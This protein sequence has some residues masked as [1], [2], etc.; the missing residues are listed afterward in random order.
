MTASDIF[1]RLAGISWEQNETGDW[2]AIKDDR[3]QAVVGLND[4][5]LMAAT[6][7]DPKFKDFETSGPI[8]EA[9]DRV[10]KILT[11]MF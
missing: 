11:G 5:G 4:N 1:N 10:S 6:F 2:L 8:E 9:R 7:N 3:I